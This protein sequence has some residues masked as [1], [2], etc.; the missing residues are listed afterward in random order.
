MELVHGM[1]QPINERPTI[2]TIGVF[3]GV[4]RGHQHLIN[5]VIRRSQQLDCQS[6]VLTF[7]PHPD[8]IIR[9]DSGRLYLASLDERIAQIEALG[10]DL[11][12]VQ[13]FS[14]EVMS[15]TASEFMHRLCGAIALRELWAGADLAIG[16]KR[17]GTLM[18]LAEI[19]RER[20]Y[21]VH[22][23]EIIAL[24]GQQI[25]STR[26]REALEEG[27]IEVVNSLLGHPFVLRGMVV[28]GDK[29]GRTIG[30]PTANISI[31]DQHMLPANGVY[32]CIVEVDGE[33]YGAVT[34]VGTRPTFDGVARKVEPYILDFNR[35]IYGE[36]LRVE[37]IHRLRGELKFDGVAALV[38]Q[39]TSDVAAAR[40]HLT[41]NPDL[42][43]D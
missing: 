29:R 8:I 9:P 32:V 7:D 14:R 12:I 35:E 2:L 28:E 43:H 5:T 42:L 4:H 18:R 41:A 13:P 25:R 21:S 37:F 19:G 17:E 39:I 26:I 36:Q 34:N 1:P 22:P 31:N 15:Q 20:G 10:V 23:V 27:Q 40:A 30:F 38:A 3:D 24:H 16:Y 11:L 33:R 6:A